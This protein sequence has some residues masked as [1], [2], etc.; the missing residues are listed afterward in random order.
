MD[1]LSAIIGAFIGA[2]GAVLAA[3]IG[4]KS[5]ETQASKPVVQL[6]SDLIRQATELSDPKRQLL[7]SLRKYDEG[8][9]IEPVGDTEQRKL[10]G[11]SF[12]STEK[13]LNKI[14]TDSGS[15]IVTLTN[16]GWKVAATIDAITKD[17]NS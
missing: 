5:T 11:Y 6:S 8:K 4:R 16:R 10:A 17:F 14:E 13:L 9:R 1:F 7:L 15:V 3:L 2:A 12:L